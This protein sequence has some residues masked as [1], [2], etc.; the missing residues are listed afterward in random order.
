MSAIESEH[1]WYHYCVFT[2]RFITQMVLSE[3]TDVSHALFISN[4]A[5]CVFVIFRRNF[6]FLFYLYVSKVV[7]LWTL[8][9]SLFE[10]ANDTNGSGRRRKNTRIFLSFFS[11]WYRNKQAK[12]LNRTLGHLHKWLRTQRDKKSGVTPKTSTTVP[13]DDM[14]YKHAVAVSSKPF[15]VTDSSRTR[16]QNV[17]KMPD[18]D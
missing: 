3:A 7:N 2:Q 1:T 5:N 15:F 9:T 13:L 18:A 11:F 4:G 6:P 8:T 14:K 12:I 10:R 16:F 17:R